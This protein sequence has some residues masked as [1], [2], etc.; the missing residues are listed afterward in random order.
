LRYSR[1]FYILF[2]K[3]TLMKLDV[4]AMGAHPDDVELSCGGTMATLARSGYK[5]GIV[6]LTQGE[7][8]TRGSKQIRKREAEESAKILGVSVRDNLK[9]PDG[10]V[11]LSKN[12]LIKVIE[13]IREAR[14]DILVIPHSMERHPDHEHAH[15]LCKEA[16]FYA[17]L[18]KI[19]TRSA[20]KKQEP[21]RPKKFFHYMQKFEFIPS[22]IIDV[23][24]F[25]SVKMDALQAFQSQFYNPRSKERRTLLSSKLFIEAIKARDIHFGSLIN[26]AFGEPFY[27]IEPLGLKSF[28]ELTLVEQ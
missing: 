24:K 1:P 16:W 23:S 17:G 12:N 25:H 8:G 7:L 26:V 21:F 22:F 27:S 10:N 4:L 13:V 28:F 3:G 5:V 9:I 18:E 15:R 6:D 2:L 19:I 20:G 11:E 14:P